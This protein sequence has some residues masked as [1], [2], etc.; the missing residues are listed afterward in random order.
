[1]Q[2]PRLRAVRERRLLTQG[3]L[4]HRAKM[5]VVTVNHAERGLRN[6]RVST[7]RRL[8]EALGVPAAELLGGND[9]PEEAAKSA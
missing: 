8:A 7:V 2:V 4:A 5:S 3:E 9:R 1:M 6:V